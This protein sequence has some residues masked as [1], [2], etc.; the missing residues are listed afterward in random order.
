MSAGTRTRIV[1]KVLERTRRADGRANEG[2]VGVHVHCPPL[3]LCVTLSRCPS[4]NCMGDRSCAVSTYCDRLSFLARKITAWN[5]WNLPLFVSLNP[6]RYFFYDVV[7]L[8]VQ[9]I[10]IASRNSILTWKLNEFGITAFP[11]CGHCRQ[12]F[13]NDFSVW[14]TVLNESK[15]SLS[16]FKVFRDNLNWIEEI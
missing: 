16:R 12:R 2:K 7:P 6:A 4:A 1:V 13:N 9:E 11:R 10:F 8:E 14:N 3:F 5:C 15:I